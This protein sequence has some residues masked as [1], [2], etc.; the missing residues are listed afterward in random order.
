MEFSYFNSSRN[1]LALESTLLS[2]S[3]RILLTCQY[4][5]EDDGMP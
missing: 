4:T 2:T 3:Y 1:V 5:V